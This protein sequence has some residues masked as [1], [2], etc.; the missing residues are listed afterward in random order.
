MSK[1]NENKT[2]FNSSHFEKLS[3]FLTGVKNE[4]EIRW[5]PEYGCVLLINNDENL[6]RHDHLYFRLLGLDSFE[7]VVHS[8]G[9]KFEFTARAKSYMT[10]MI[11][12]I[13][14]TKRD[15]FFVKF[16]DIF[17]SA[18]RNKG[19]DRSS[20]GNRQ[21]HQKTPAF[22]KALLLQALGCNCS[23]KY[24]K[25]GQN[26]LPE[27]GCTDVGLHTG[28]RA[29]C[30]EYELV[31]SVCEWKL[32]MMYFNDCQTSSWCHEPSF[33]L[34]M[35]YFDTYILE[36]A[37]SSAEKEFCFSF[38]GVP[39][40]CAK[41]W[42]I[43]KKLCYRSAILSDHGYTVD[44]H[45]LKVKSL[46][47][48][49]YK[50]FGKVQDMHR[51]KNNI[52]FRLP[53]FESFESPRIVPAQLDRKDTDRKE[54]SKNTLDARALEFVPSFDFQNHNS[55]SSAH[56]WALH[57]KTWHE[58]VISLQAFMS[59]MER[60]FWRLEMYLDKPLEDKEDIV[61]LSKILDIY[62]EYVEKFLK[63]SKFAKSRTVRFR[64]IE[65]LATWLVY[66]V[67]FNGIRG[68]YPKVLLNE[69]G[70]ALRYQDLSHLVLQS[71]KHSKI[72][73]RIVSF[74]KTNCRENSEIFCGR[75]DQTWSSATFKMGYLYTKSF[76]KEI[77]M[78]EKERA[79][80]RVDLHWKE[81]EKRQKLSKKLRN[82]L[83]N[84]QKNLMSE[85][86]E[87]SAV[88][89]EYQKALDEWKSMSRQCSC[90][91]WS[92]NILCTCADAFNAMENA[93]RIF[94][95]KDAQ[96]E[97]TRIEISKK[98]SEIFE[99]EKPPDP[100]IQPLPQDEYR[101]MAVLFFLHMPEEFVILANISFISQQLLVPKPRL[102]KYYTGN[103]FSK[104]DVL[105]QMKVNK[106][107]I[108]W[109]D[110]CNKYNADKRK[111]NAILLVKISMKK[112]VD[113]RNIGSSSVLDYSTEMDGVFY[114]DDNDIR[115]V[116]FG[117]KL[118]SDKMDA[119]IEFNPFQISSEYSGECRSFI[120]KI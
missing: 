44:S 34:V 55:I 6:Q 37:V 92:R 18:S 20:R 42:K 17:D 41:L 39:Q 60:I 113:K 106:R 100:V 52:L 69:F 65:L 62:R 47:E 64:S 28:G 76:L 9:D 74:L 73:L 70:V 5:F 32:K 48:R 108:P 81:I 107:Y 10:D 31:K 116:W 22:I 63:M 71:E 101:S 45:L 40:R 61:R 43:Q 93:E 112:E 4:D 46:K 119:R 25:C 19:A 86:D 117:G 98:Q 29:R 59:D 80:S 90:S 2:D 53:S 27:G 95:R 8:T 7:R 16:R 58:T 51:M 79:D 49:I 84:L 97:R 54:T 82:E 118:L 35:M 30:T 67:I 36:T 109:F 87:C 99:A 78:K 24:C 96:K 3:E 57:T 77:Y 13:S 38:D 56:K 85:S 66:C 26:V 115:L 89:V 14:R 105:G 50:L 1:E 11:G 15:S 110:H 114:P 21:G 102:L 83:E 94:L 72:L 104:V 111:A 33:D 88:L 12:P 120:L 68:H 103:S 75:K 91:K 23:A